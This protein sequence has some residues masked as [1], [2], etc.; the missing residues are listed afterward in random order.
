MSISFTEAS[1]PKTMRKK[2][3][4]ILLQA[5][6]PKTRKPDQA[7]TKQQ[8]LTVRQAEQVMALIAMAE[9]VE[10]SELNTPSARAY[11]SAYRHLLEDV[12][13]FLDFSISGSLIP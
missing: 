4:S 1:P 3:P 5:H 7:I 8:L 11:H 13:D 10:V 9:L 2:A 6:Y 12:D